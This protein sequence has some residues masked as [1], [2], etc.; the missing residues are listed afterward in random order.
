MRIYK[1]VCA[2]MISGKSF[3]TSQTRVSSPAH[4]IIL[5]Q[6]SL[7]NAADAFVIFVSS[8]A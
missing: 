6:C 1:A 3:L 8:P 4:Y 2:A 7:G 5:H